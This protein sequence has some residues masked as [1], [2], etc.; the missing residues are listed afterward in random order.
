MAISKE[1][2]ASILEDLTKIVKDSL[3]LVLVNFKGLSVSDSKTIR[4]ALKEKGVGYYVAKNTLTRRALS[5]GSI[6]GDI[7]DFSGETALVYGKDILSPAQEIYAFQKKLDKKITII[8][9]VFDGKF[10]NKDEMTVVANIPGVKT[11]HAQF[12]NL[13]NSPISG[14]VVA[15]N[16]IANKKEN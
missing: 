9:G 13:I 16:A 10:M 1:K 4:R 2:K 7:P 8:G 14:F 5:S 12:V 15:L 3:S 11:L 6:K